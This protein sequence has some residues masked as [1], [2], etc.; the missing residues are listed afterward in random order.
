[1]SVEGEL[2]MLLNIEKLEK[3]YSLK[4]RRA[5]TKGAEHFAKKLKENTPVS[6]V[7][8]DIGHLAEHIKVLGTS[9]KTGEFEA[10]IGYD[11]QKGRIAHFPNSGT[12]RQPAQ[13]FIE[14]TQAEELKAIQ[15]IFVKE[16][17]T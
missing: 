6:D 2:E 14:K 4:A 13:H 8:S 15:A 10:M 1:M 12:S 11:K 5:V 9:V 7:E 16:L 17:K 3:G